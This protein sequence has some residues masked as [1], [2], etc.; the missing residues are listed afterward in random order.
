MT[1]RRR[2][3]V[4][5]ALVAACV[6]A[7]AISMVRAAGGDEESSSAAAARGQA[8]VGGSSRGPVLVFRSMDLR[9]KSTF[10]RVITA[11]AGLT[12]Q[13]VAL[14]AVGCLAGAL[15]F[16]WFWTVLVG[17][18]ITWRHLFTQKVTLNYPEEK[19][20]LPPKSRMRLFMKYEDCIGCGQCARACPVGPAALAI[21]SWGHPQLGAACTGCGVCIAACV[22]APSSISASPFSGASA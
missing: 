6:I 17:M 15:L 12:H 21:D 2:R 18:K 16:R 22:T 8:P 5:V 1:D 9:H 14:F 10:G 19:W 3:A 13:G 4:F 20:Q 7:V 11:N